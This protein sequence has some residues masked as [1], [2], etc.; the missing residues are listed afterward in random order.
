MM[1]ACLEE[2]TWRKGWI[3]DN[4]LAKAA[5]QLGAVAYADCLKDITATSA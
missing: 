1:V 3:D 2:I 5:R 4:A